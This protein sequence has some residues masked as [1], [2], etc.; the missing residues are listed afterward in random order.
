[1]NMGEC[2][3]RI[4]LSCPCFFWRKSRD[5][6]RY[7]E[8]FWDIPRQS[9]IKRDKAERAEVA[10]NG[11]ANGRGGRC[12]VP[13]DGDDASRPGQRR[14]PRITTLPLPARALRRASPRGAIRL[15]HGRMI[16][17]TPDAVHRTMVRGTGR[18]AR[19][20]PS[21]TPAASAHPGLIVRDRRRRRF[22]CA[23]PV[24]RMATSRERRRTGKV[25]PFRRV[26][27]G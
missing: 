13:A 6:P 22:R 26:G 20:C 9:E 16:A 15:P 19:G 11:G 3:R 7:S 24:P 5:I 27:G 14:G 12:A 8:I 4:S 10:P 17:R 2:R 21:P 25:A 1:M 18:D 23:R